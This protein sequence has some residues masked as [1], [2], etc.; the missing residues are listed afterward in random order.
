MTESQTQQT[1]Q[2]ELIVALNAYKREKPSEDLVIRLNE[3]Q[4]ELEADAGV[5]AVELDDIYNV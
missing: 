2:E 3:L 4:R 5:T 1:P